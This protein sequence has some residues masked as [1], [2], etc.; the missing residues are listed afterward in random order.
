MAKKTKFNSMYRTTWSSIKS[1]CDPKALKQCDFSKGLGPALDKLSKNCDK[2]WDKPEVS[3]KTLQSLK[4]EVEGVQKIIGKYFAQIKKGNETLPDHGPSWFNLHQALKHVDEQLIDEL[5]DLGV[6]GCK[7]L[8]VWLGKGDFAKPVVEG[9]KKEDVDLAGDVKR[10]VDNLSTKKVDAIAKTLGTKAPGAFF[11][12]TPRIAESIIPQANPFSGAIKFIDQKLAE[13]P[14]KV[15][16]AK[17]TLGEI[18]KRL[19][20]IYKILG[21][22]KTKLKDFLELKFYGVLNTQI[23]AVETDTK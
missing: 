15:E 19:D 23:I 11:P 1:Q 12:Y 22:D 16:L 9:T 7:K 17:E 18:R 6:P 4:G 10:L 14:P 21:K 8:G 2:A 20:E 3:D 5:K 13:K